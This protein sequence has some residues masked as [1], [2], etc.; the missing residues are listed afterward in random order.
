MKKL[1]IEKM[2]LTNEQLE[3]TAEVK[4]KNIDC[5]KAER[6]FSESLDKL[7]KLD[8]ALW[9]ELEERESF[10]EATTENAIYK[11][12]FMDGIKFLHTM[13]SGNMIPSEGVVEDEE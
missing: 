2:L 10:I 11:L 9:Q 4:K 5:V 3:R 1:D 13:L 12:G 7:E 8:H 6:E